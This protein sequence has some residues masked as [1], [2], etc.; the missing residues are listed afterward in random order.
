[1][2]TVG[3]QGLNVLSLE[4][5]RAVEMSRLIETYGGKVI[6]APSMREVPLAENKHAIEFARGLIAGHYDLVLFLTGVGARALLQMLSESKMTEAFLDALRHVKVAVR[7]PKPLSVL[8]EWNVPVAFT[9][10]EPCT[11]HELLAGL[12]DQRGGLQ[13]LRVAVQEYGVSNE[14][15]LGALRERGAI[16]NEIAVYR[17]ELPVDTAPLRAAITDVIEQKVDVVLFTTGVQATHLFRI[18]EEMGEQQRLRAAFQ[19]VMVASIGPATTETLQSFGLG[20]DL[21]TSHPKMG[22]LVREAA[23]QSAVLTADKKLIH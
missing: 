3:F 10:P 17:W 4:S 9:A 18:A 11:W 15:F 21:E 13:G 7:G 23:E 22:L 16:V 6:A 14:E 20:V 19:R 2:P 5:R 8:R 12:V 1:L